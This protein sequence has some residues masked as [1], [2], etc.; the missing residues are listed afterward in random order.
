[1]SDICGFGGFDIVDSS[2][3][4]NQS[5]RFFVPIFLHAGVVHLLLNMMAQCFS[6][7]LVR[8][9]S[10]CLPSSHPNREAGTIL[11]D[12]LLALTLVTFPSP[13]PLH[14]DVFTVRFRRSSA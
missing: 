9:A 14:L 10:L 4:P 13:L 6:S 2:S 3:G 12:E 8:C 11:P 5:F 1:M 7:A